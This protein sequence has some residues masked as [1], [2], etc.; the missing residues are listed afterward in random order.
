MGWISEFRDFAIK[1]NMVDM[2]VGIVIGAGFGKVVS[3]FVN[4]I[5][6]PFAGLFTGG[7]DFSGLSL[8]LKKDA[9]TDASGKSIDLMLTWGN[10][11]Q[12]LIDFLIV[13]FAIFIVV[14]VIHTAKARFEAQQEAAADAAGPSEEVK[15]LTE[16]R[17]AMQR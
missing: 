9:V 14:K 5:I 15:L 3:S 16:I 7:T 6:S 8:V 11:L 12:T 1:G 17:D 10:F 13:A 4:D 2:A